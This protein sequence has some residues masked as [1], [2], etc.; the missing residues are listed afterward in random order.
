[1]LPQATFST[2]LGEVLRPPPAWKMGYLLLCQLPST[3]AW[4][5]TWATAE[6]TLTRPCDFSAKHRRDVRAHLQL[7]RNGAGWRPGRSGEVSQRRRRVAHRSR[8]NPSAASFARHRK[9]SGPSAKRTLGPRTLDLDLLLYGQE[10]IAVKGPNMELIVSASATCMKALCAGTSGGNRPVG[11]ASGT[12]EHH[13]RLVAT[14]TRHTSE[15]GI[16]GRV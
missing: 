15:P 7:S 1:M 2:P 10:Q 4:A 8:T 6:T 9:Q 12:K 13:T 14:G 11:C 3:S 16:N 5:A